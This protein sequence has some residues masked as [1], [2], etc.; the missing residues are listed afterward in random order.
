MCT[1]RNDD[2]IDINVCCICFVHNDD[3]IEGSGSDGIYSVSV[4]GG[5]IKTVLKKWQQ[6]MKVWSAFTLFCQQVHTVS[7]YSI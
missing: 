6:T 1:D 7:T 5:S 3:V 2:G 4:E